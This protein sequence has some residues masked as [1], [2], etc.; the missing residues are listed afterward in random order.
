MATLTLRTEVQKALYEIELVG[1]FSDGT[2]ENSRPM[3]HWKPWCNCNVEVGPNA[4]RDFYPRRDKYNL[5]KSMFMEVCG[6]RMLAYARL[7]RHVGIEDAKELSELVDW[8]NDDRP[9]LRWNFDGYED[10][11]GYWAKLR[12]L[13]RKFDEKY[14]HE[15][16]NQVVES[17]DEYTIKDLRKDL[18]EIARAMRTFNG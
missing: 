6:S 3:D 11:G 18:R 16:L 4:G 7:T 9:C 2:W 12:E 10:G 15:Y 8:T 17:D 14:G 13:A 1:Q 5:T